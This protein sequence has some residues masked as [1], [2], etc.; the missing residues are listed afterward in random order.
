MAESPENRR[1]SSSSSSSSSS[2][3]ASV[4]IEREIGAGTSGSFNE[5][6]SREGADTGSGS[7]GSGLV[8]NGGTDSS[9]SSDFGLS[10]WIPLKQIVYFIFSS[11]V[12]VCMYVQVC[13]VYIL[14]WIVS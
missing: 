9:G 14:L 5:L 3:E 8:N 10:K 4:K 6:E 12:V 13:N 11:L 2:G 1:N 7:G